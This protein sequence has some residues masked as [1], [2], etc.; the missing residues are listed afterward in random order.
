MPS[1]RAVVAVVG[2]ALAPLA[3]AVPAVAAPM[4]QCDGIKTTRVSGGW[5]VTTPGV[6][7]D[8]SVDC[9]LKYGDLPHRN[10]D[11]P[12][13]DPAGAIKTLQR[14]LNFCYQ[15]NLRIDGLYG[16]NVREAVKKVQRQHK[17]TV[18]GVYGPK[19]RSAMNWRMY[20]P[21]TKVWTNA[22]Y[23]YI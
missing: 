1:V 14:N 16:A 21:T 9:N 12:F 13:G 15:A 10:P 17:L 6:W 5:Q 23:S 8:T 18:D 4:G 11:I 19:T 2:L 20:H 7:E 22:C 3:V